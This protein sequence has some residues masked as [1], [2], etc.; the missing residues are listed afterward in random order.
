MLRGSASLACVRATGLQLRHYTE[1]VRVYAGAEAL[2][3]E[4]WKAG[5]LNPDGTLRKARC[6]CGRAIGPMRD[7]AVPQCSGR[8]SAAVLC[9]TPR[10]S[11]NSRPPGPARSKH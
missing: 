2:V 11:L 1:R 4:W 5:I 7:E 10:R 3:H 9:S 6:V 8:L